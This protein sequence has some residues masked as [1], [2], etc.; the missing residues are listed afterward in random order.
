MS[1]ALRLATAKEMYIGCRVQPKLRIKAVRRHTGL[2]LPLSRP[3][4]F[5]ESN[6]AHRPESSPGGRTL[7]PTARSPIRLRHYVLDT[8]TSIA[9]LFLF[10]ISIRVVRFSIRVVR[11]QFPKL[12][13]EAFDELTVAI[14]AELNGCGFQLDGFVQVVIDD[15]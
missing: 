2:C 10:R 8:I 5:S 3:A 4:N 12:L 9:Y 11:F 6:K 13:Q 1:S 7:G 14:P 15:L